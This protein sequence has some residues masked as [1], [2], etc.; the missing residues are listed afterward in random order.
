MVR[1]IETDLFAGKWHFYTRFFMA[2]FVSFKIR[3]HNSLLKELVKVLQSA[4]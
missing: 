2:I 3:F 1:R 4:E